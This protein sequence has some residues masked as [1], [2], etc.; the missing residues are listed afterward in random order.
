MLQK[1]FLYFKMDFLNFHIDK[2]DQNHIIIIFF[3][4]HNLKNKLEKPQLKNC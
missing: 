2:L 3:Y 1:L 4:K